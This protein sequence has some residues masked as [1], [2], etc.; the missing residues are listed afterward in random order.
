M[1]RRALTA[2]LAT[3][4]ALSACSTS[5][6]PATVSTPTSAARPSA[7]QLGQAIEFTR[8]DSGARIGRIRFT[9]AR[10]LGADCTA[11]KRDGHTLALRVEIQ[12]GPG[13]QLPVPD[14]YSLKYNDANG[15]TRDTQ[16]AVIY[17]CEAD[18][19]EATT[20]PPGG[21][22]EGWFAIRA[23][24][25]PAALVY[26]PLVGDQSSTAGNIKILAVSP[27]TVTLGL[28]DQL[29]AEPPSSTTAA[30]PAPSTSTGQPAP[31]APP[32]GRDSEGRPNGTG[33]KIV[34][35]AD[36]NY[37]PGTGIYADGSK[38]FAPECLPGGALA[39]R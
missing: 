6:T 19:P 23:P 35:C 11:G 34:A 38:G 2:L 13:E 37:Q 16:T 9:E 31:A 17:D 1:T 22:T 27:A 14:T 25:L 33:G 24:E 10:E 29:G 7:L 20:A 15:V 21:R 3:A 4:A 8:T 30:R 26:S 12:N 28:P 36:E 5:S 39:P 18:Y 32:T